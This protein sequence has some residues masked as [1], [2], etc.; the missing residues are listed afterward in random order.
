MSRTEGRP[1]PTPSCDI[2]SR[3]EDEERASLR[4]CLNID[5][6]CSSGFDLQSYG[7]SKVVEVYCQGVQLG[8]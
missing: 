8:A 2:K 4:R 1:A 7:I 3:G 6:V 5:R